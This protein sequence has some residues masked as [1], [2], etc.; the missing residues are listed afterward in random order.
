MRKGFEMTTHSRAAVGLATAGLLLAVGGVLHPRVDTAV[1]FEAGLVGMFESGAWVM[2]H[3]LTMAGFAVL[4]ASLAVLVRGSVWGRIAVAGA[5]LAAV[6]SLPHLL[7][8]SEADALAGGGSTPL[9]DLHTVLQAL[10]TPAVGLSIA[11]LAVVSAR[12]HALGSGR[13]AAALAVVGGIAFALAGP[14]IALTENSELS[15]L[16]AGSAG[17][18][19]W[20]LVSGARLAR[21]AEMR[22]TLGMAAAR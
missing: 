21:R 19:L 11:A 13:F 12:T 20:C 2:A 16:F 4:A 9:T 8:A 22:G 1:E 17:I 10:A 7:A 15:P 6:E 5:A 3:A 14:A 18:S